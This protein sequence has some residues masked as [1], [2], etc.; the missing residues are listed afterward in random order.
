MKIGTILAYTH[1]QIQLGT[2][3]VYSTKATTTDP[4]LPVVGSKMRNIISILRTFSQLNETILVKGASGSG[5]SRLALWCHKHSSRAHQPFEVLD[6]SS[7]PEEMQMAELFGW[8]K[9]AFTGSVSNNSGYVGRA[10]EG[11]L[12]I[13]EV[14]KLS[15]KAQA[16]LLQLLESNTYKPLGDDHSV[17]RANVRFIVGTNANLPKLI[18]EGLFREDLY[19][20]INVFPV[21]VPDLNE[22]KDEISLWANYMLKRHHQDLNKEK[23]I[24]AMISDDAQNILLTHPWPGNLRQLDNIIRRAYAMALSESMLRH[25]LII[26]ASHI[27]RS[28][29]MDSHIAGDDLMDAMSNTAKLFVQKAIKSCLER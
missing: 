2:K 21:E 28:L 8:V 12:F 16:G 22:R 23:N 19:F 1:I 13:D 14:D 5:K 26:Q 3:M 17:R 11:T 25:R 15:L 29:S 24:E 6:L 18:K 9:G 7:V 20:R 10:S 4:Y 27:K